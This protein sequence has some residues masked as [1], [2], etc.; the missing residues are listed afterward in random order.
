VIVKGNCERAWLMA[1]LEMRG[2]SGSAVDRSG[3]ESR[4]GERDTLD[5]RLSVRVRIGVDGQDRIGIG[6]G[7]DTGPPTLNLEPPASTLH[8][9]L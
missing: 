5:T 1:V 7:Q 3:V 8:Y 4:L 9:R 6:R 2:M